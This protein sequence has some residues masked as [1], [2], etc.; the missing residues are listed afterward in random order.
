M[1]IYP[2][3]A[4]VLVTPPAFFPVSLDEA[5]NQCRVE[6][7]DEDGL[8]NMLIG[9]A[10]QHLDG[11]GGILRGRCLV[12]QTWRQDFASFSGC[13]R[14]LRLPLSP[15]TA[16][17]SVGYYDTAN[18]LQ[19][20]AADAYR[21][22]ND[23]LGPYLERNPSTSYPGVYG[24]RPDAVGVTFTAGY[25]DP[26]KVPLPLRQ[27]ILLHVSLLYEHRG[28]AAIELPDAY[29]RLIAPFR[30]TRI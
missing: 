14:G 28:D 17:V 7:A 18:A 10:A 16:I 29:W 25:G 15:V 30:N 12:T 4:P 2:P 21:L 27:A 5:K 20:L 3:L 23:H 26:L 24:S 19:T 13:D 11:Y 6:H 1:T 9:A 22:I 8:F